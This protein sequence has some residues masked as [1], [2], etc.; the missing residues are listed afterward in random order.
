MHANLFGDYVKGSDLSAYSK[1]VQ[2]GIRLHRQIDSYIDHHPDV[3]KLMHTMYQDLP[4]VTGIAIDLFFDHL[5][6]SNWNEYH[7]Q[8]YDDF[9]KTFYQSKS[10]YES[11]FS[12]QYLF[13]FERMKEYNWLHYYQFHEGLEKAC[14]GLSQ[15]ISFASDLN[16]APD[17]FLE[18]KVDI[19]QC[20]EK[21]MHDA[22]IFF[23]DYIDTHIS[24]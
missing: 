19:E 24:V 1:P 5:L 17:L 18:R 16:K 15:R 11:E 2:E 14:V 8:P 23:N 7:S 10:Q 6:A 3:L 12:E 9:I 21:F 4:K 20:F 13:M 22:R